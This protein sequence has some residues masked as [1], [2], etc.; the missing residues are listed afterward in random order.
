MRRVVDDDLA[1][2]VARRLV[3]VLAGVDLVAVDALTLLRLE[4]LR[5]DAALVLVVAV[6][7]LALEI[8]N[9]HVQLL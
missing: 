4:D 3:L 6:V 7:T 5:A 8:E 2:L 1:A 9:R